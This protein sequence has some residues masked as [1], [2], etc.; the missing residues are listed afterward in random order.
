MFLLVY[1]KTD[2]ANT[3][4]ESFFKK[5]L[6]DF[7]SK[8]EHGNLIN[9]YLEKING[10]DALIGNIRGSVGE[11]GVYYRIA[12][13]KANN[14]FYKIIIGVSEN[15]KSSYDEDMDKIIRGFKKIS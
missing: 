1:K 12:A 3:S 15:M 9:F 11:T 4:L 14:S 13:I 10:E 6:N 5:H 7:A 2:S 8:L